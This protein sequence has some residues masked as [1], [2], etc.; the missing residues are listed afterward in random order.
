MG[1]YYGKGS[2]VKEDEKDLKEMNTMKEGAKLKLS[3][4]INTNR[5][6]EEKE[7]DTPISV[8]SETGQD[9]K[10]LLMKGDIDECVTF[11]FENYRLFSLCEIRTT[12]ETINEVFSSTILNGIKHGINKQIT[13]HEEAYKEDEKINKR[14]KHLFYELELVSI[15]TKEKG[16]IVKKEI[17][18]LISKNICTNTRIH[19]LVCFL[20]EFLENSQYNPLIIDNML[21]V[22][23][24]FLSI[25]NPMKYKRDKTQ[26]KYNDQKIDEKEVLIERI[27]KQIDNIKQKKKIS[28]NNMLLVLLAVVQYNELLQD[29]EFTFSNLINMIK[30][31]NK[32]TQVD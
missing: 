5:K 8:I 9:F 30:Q 21:L 25:I 18:D 17:E 27:E 28:Q 26:T 6:E 23:E 32:L 15:L 16:T 7:K 24:M 12:P 3:E 1:S 19:I 4:I 20:I 10:K 11:L 13:T 14:N 22:I 29:N 2:E 31:P